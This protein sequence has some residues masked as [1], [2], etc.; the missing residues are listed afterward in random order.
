MKYRVSIDEKEYD[1]DVEAVSQAGFS[2]HKNYDAVQYALDAVK[3]EYEHCI[4]RSEKLDNKIYILLTVCTF[5][6]ALPISSISKISNINMPTKVVG[7]IALI[8]FIVMLLVTILL[9]IYVLFKLVK[10]LGG[11]KIKRLDPIDIID[12]DLFS[13]EPQVAARCISRIYY[14]ALTENNEKLEHRFEV[15]NQCVKL[16]FPI[17]ILSLLEVILETLF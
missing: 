3:L 12:A 9:L 6:F 8:I 10:L 14:D 15:F 16:L 1:V 17:I 4:Q 7:L 11:I 5:I 13:I 2:I